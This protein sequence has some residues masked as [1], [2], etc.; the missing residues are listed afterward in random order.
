MVQKLQDTI[1]SVKQELNNV[2]KEEYQHTSTS[3]RNTEITVVTQ[4]KTSFKGKNMINRYDIK[5]KKNL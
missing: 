1:R 4:E 3:G 5:L 2:S